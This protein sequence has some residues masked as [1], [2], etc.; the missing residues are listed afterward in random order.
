MNNSIKRKINQ[1][2]KFNFGLS[3]LSST[4]TDFMSKSNYIKKPIKQNGGRRYK[5]SCNDLFKSLKNKNFELILYILRENNCCFKCQDSNGNNGL[6]LLIPY[7]RTNKEIAN[8]VDEILLNADCEDF[9]NIQNNKGRTPMFVAVENNLDELAEKMEDAGA[10]PEIKDL[11]GNFVGEKSSKGKLNEMDDN[12][13]PESNIKKNIMNIYSFVVPKSTSNDLTSLNLDDIKNITTQDKSLDT[14]NFMQDIKLK[15]NR[16]LGTD[17]SSTTDNKTIPK[18]NLIQTSSDTLNSDKF[19]ALL[20]RD[21]EPMVVSYSDIDDNT[22]QFIATLT[23]K[24]NAINETDKSIKKPKITNPR[25]VEY[26][27]LGSLFESTD[28]DK[29]SLKPKQP[30]STETSLDEIISDNKIKKLVNET[31]SDDLIKSD[32]KKKTSNNFKKLESETSLNPLHTDLEKYINETTS[33]ESIGTKAKTKYNVFL[34]KENSYG[35]KNLDTTE[36]DTNTLLGVIKKIQDNNI[37]ESENLLDMIGGG[38]K[39]NE[40]H[41]IGHR[42]LILNNFKKTQGNKPLNSD[43]YNE[44]YNSDSEFGTKSKK[45]KNLNNELSRM[46]I[47]Q[48]EKIHKEVLEM[49]MGMLNK[50]LITQSNKPL[51]PSERNAKLIKAYIYRQISE[52]NPQMGGMDKIMM[53]KAMSENDIIGAVKK[54]PELDELEKTIQKHLEDKK[55]NKKSIDVSETVEASEISEELKKPKKKSS[56]K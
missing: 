31:T 15:I 8:M 50:G 51:E 35:D 29:I 7:Y 23:N 21:N 25:N 52:K 34:K 38:S 2:Y 14:D 6:H 13:E 41:I 27:T 45:S 16:A 44:L 20:G 49:I 26:D 46:M 32:I 5:C 28:I 37:T 24:Y 43:D 22:D 17:D 39:K 42:K 12:D 47:S 10:D 18:P 1:N 33:D 36:I 3:E 53:F 55:T 40:Q 4:S 54:M 9:I 48:K 19:L 30:L 11:Q 56:K